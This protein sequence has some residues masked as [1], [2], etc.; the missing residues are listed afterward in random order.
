MGLMKFGMGQWIKILDTGLLPGKLIQQLNGQAQRMVGQQALGGKACTTVPLQN[1][2][3][4]H[5]KAL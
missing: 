3:K 5:S 1:H 4:S 2:F